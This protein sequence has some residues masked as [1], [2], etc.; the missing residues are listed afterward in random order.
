MTAP[1]PHGYPDWQRQLSVADTQLI[2]N[3]AITVGIGATV[4]RGPFYIGNYPAVT[5]SFTS[6]PGRFQIALRWFADEAL[7]QFITDTRVRIDTSFAF[8][9]AVSV[10][11]PWLQVRIINEGAAG[12]SIA[13]G[14]TTTSHIGMEQP[15][16]PDQNILVRQTGISV[17]AGATRTDDASRVWG[18]PV[19][20]S[21]DTDAVAYSFRIQ[22][23]DS[24]GVFNSYMRLDDAGRQPPF[25]YY[26]PLTPVRL[27]FVNNDAAARSYRAALVGDVGVLR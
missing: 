15:T 4:N 2:T 23:M 14:L 7:T 17:A 25:I 21:F 12:T 8:T 3:T 5:C 20:V 19:A 10:K 9:G 13:T 26:L 18:G 16:V 11:G 22:N 6:A 24:A 27:L 1:V